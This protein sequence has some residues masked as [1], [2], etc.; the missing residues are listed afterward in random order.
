MLVESV[1]QNKWWKT[2]WVYDAKIKANLTSGWT[3]PVIEMLMTDPLVPT[4]PSHTAVSFDQIRTR[5]ILSL[6][7]LLLSISDYFSMHI[8]QWDQ[9]HICLWLL[10]FRGIR[11]QNILTV[12]NRV[13]F[14]SVSLKP[15]SIF[16]LPITN[17]N[18][19]V[20]VLTRHLSVRFTGQTFKGKQE[21][22]QT[23]L[24]IIKCL[25]NL[26]KCV[27]R[28]LIYCTANLTVI[29]QR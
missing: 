24:I 23:I 17:Y 9:P 28:Y 29:W 4:K 5:L 20:Q 14:Y 13:L 6:G 19:C 2:S 7:H 10:A 8:W 16:I 27:M 18:H 15:L 22:D 11:T 12:C 1:C 21:P 3:F 26:P 25:R